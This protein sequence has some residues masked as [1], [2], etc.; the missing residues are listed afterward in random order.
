MT[1]FRA[2]ALSLATVLSAGSLVLLG[3]TASPAPNA[4]PHKEKAVCPFR[5]A[6]QAHCDAH[7]QTLDDG[8]TPAAGTS[9][10]AGSYGPADLQ[11]A[12]KLP[13]AGAGETV[14]IVD[15]YDEP[16][17]ASDLAAYRSQYG[18]PA[19]GAGCFQKV[20][21][22][23]ATSPLPAADAGWG[24]EIALDV[25]MVSATCPSCHILLV[26]ANSPT[27][28]NLGTAENTAAHSANA[29]SNSYGGSEFSGETAYDSY[30]NHPGVAI[31]VSS[32]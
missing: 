16:N 27:Y 31:T 26:E 9:P 19:C 22:N 18:L 29:V 7:V 15:A 30:Y 25:E 8:V 14:A 10:A 11:S 32:G 1:R 4:H 23:G 28:A 24:Q 21:Q 3:G 5:P 12:Y 17:V 13:S 2:A 20:N 6:H